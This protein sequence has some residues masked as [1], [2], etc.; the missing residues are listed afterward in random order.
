IVPNIWCN[1][2]ADEAGAFYA[3][4]FPGTTAT[5]GATYPNEVDDWQAQF[6]GKTLTVDVTIDGYLLTLINAGDEFR[7][8][9][10]VSFMLNFDPL[11][12]DGDRDA[13]RTS[14]DETWA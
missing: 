11:R 3:D 14:L 1:Q 7:P 6:A 12:F 13:A 5:V 2:N 9:P 4:V 8:N 10:S